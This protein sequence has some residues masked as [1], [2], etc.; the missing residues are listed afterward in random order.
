[1]SVCRD[2]AAADGYAQNMDAATCWM[3]NDAECGYVSNAQIQ[4]KQT[5]SDCTALRY[6]VCDRYHVPSDDENEMRRR[7]MEEND[8]WWRDT[9][10]EHFPQQQSAQGY[11]DEDSEEEA[12]AQRQQEYAAEDV[13]EDDMDGEVDEAGASLAA[14]SEPLSARKKKE[15]AP[16]TAPKKKKAKKKTAEY[17][18]YPLYHMPPWMRARRMRMRKMQQMGLLHP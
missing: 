3:S 2:T 17:K 13:P 11:Y 1:M 8:A 18:Q 10:F 6:F 5:D 15:K 7:M 14:P 4:T 16:D 12:P 9:Y